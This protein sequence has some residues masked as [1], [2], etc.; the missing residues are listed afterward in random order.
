ME[1]KR[2]SVLYRENCGGVLRSVARGLRKTV[3]S[4]ADVDLLFYPVK[5]SSQS[6]AHRS[7]PLA[8]V[9][10]RSRSI[11]IAFV[12]KGGSNFGP[13]FL[14]VS[15]GYSS[16]LTDRLFQCRLHSR[17]PHRRRLCSRSMLIYR[18]N[19]VSRHWC[20]RIPPDRTSLP[21]RT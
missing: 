7:A 12:T 21:P 3:S 1:R 4:L 15:L 13:P 10:R 8:Q 14:S 18:C 19:Q 9:F 17:Q 2:I 5:F 16:V 11:L 6:V 20:R